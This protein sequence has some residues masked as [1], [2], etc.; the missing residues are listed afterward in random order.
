MVLFHFTSCNGCILTC[1]VVGKF[2]VWCSYHGLVN[3]GF[4]TYFFLSFHGEMDRSLLSKFIFMLFLMS[5]SVFIS[6]YQ[7]FWVYHSSIPE[8]LVAWC[9][10]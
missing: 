7:S 9:T 3:I 4:D 2:V 10:S 1:L 8:K 6:L 5:L